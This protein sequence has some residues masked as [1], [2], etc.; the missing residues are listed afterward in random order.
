MN[1]WKSLE[2]LEI[3]WNYDC[4]RIMVWKLSGNLILTFAEKNQEEEI[5]LKNNL[6]DIVLVLQR[7]ISKISKILLF[8]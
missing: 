5:S 2:S 1:V 8:C 4:F 3:V 6:P 7:T